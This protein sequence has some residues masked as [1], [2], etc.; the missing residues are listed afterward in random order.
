MKTYF[1][2]NVACIKS[3]F[4]EIDLNLPFVVSLL[5]LLLILL[6]LKFHIE[7]QVSFEGKSSEYSMHFLH[8]SILATFFVLVQNTLKKQTEGRTWNI[9]EKEKI[10][11]IEILQHSY[12]HPLLVQ[13]YFLQIEKA[14]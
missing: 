2:N 10:T 12:I 1:I 4:E 9:K 11:K 3:V 14:A 7:F 6:N 13:F 8:Y 5:L